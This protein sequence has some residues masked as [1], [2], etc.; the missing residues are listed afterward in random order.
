VAQS[1][2]SGSAASAENE[3][4]AL[5]AAASEIAIILERRR[6]ENHESG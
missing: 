4:A 6:H 1:S 2:E 3:M 5:K